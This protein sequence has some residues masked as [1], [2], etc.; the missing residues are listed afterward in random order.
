MP[1]PKQSHFKKAGIQQKK[2]LI[3]CNDAM[4]KCGKTRFG[5]TMP[6]PLAIINLDEGL[7]SVIQEF[8]DK[9]E[10]YVSDHR[11]GVVDIK[12]MKAGGKS[13]ADAAAEEWAKVKGAYM[14]GLEEARSVLVDTG[15]EFY[16]LLRLAAFGKLTQ[17]MPHQYGVVNREMK[18]MIDLA[19]DSSANVMFTHRLKREYV[20]DKSTKNMIRAG[21]GDFGYECQV[22]VRQWK[23]ASEPFPDR[24]HMM[25]TDCRIPAGS[26]LEGEDYMG[27]MV[28]FPFLASMIFGNDLEDWQ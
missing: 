28:N 13:V 10:I 9:K 12:N 18:A 4:P 2:R 22:V 8:Q 24:F 7:D 16:E 21:W 6:G 3:V 19:Y 11:K 5:L 14:E 25:M 17:V 15:T 26:Q 27:E 20:D 23:D 1:S